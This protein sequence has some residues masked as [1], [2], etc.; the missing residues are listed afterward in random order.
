MERGK[1]DSVQESSYFTEKLGFNN[2]WIFVLLFIELLIYGFVILS[3]FISGLSVFQLPVSFIGTTSIALIVVLTTL[4]F[5]KLKL[6]VTVTEEGI[7]YRMMPFERKGHL[8]KPEEI[9]KY[10]I[11]RAGKKRKSPAQKTGL[12]VALKTGKKL[13]IQTK[14]PKQFI[15]A[16]HRLMEV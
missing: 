10:F 16:V 9:E 3:R 7:R 6:Q 4:L 14:H 12:F 1:S 8:V 15:K 5:F 11:K 13:F 2:R